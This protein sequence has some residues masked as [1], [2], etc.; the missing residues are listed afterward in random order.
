MV[1]LGLLRDDASVWA[2]SV[3]YL[4]FSWEQCMQL[5]NE[6]D[7]ICKRPHGDQIHMA[8]PDFQQN[9]PLVFLHCP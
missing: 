1:K 8:A 2:K 6:I 9:T 7:I 3:A 5:E 4:N